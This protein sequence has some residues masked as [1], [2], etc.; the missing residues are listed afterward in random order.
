MNENTGQQNKTQT[1]DP[2]GSK[3]QKITEQHVSKKQVKLLSFLCLALQNQGTYPAPPALINSL[4]VVAGLRLRQV[5]M[6]PCTLQ[7]NLITLKCSLGS[8]H[9]RQ[10]PS[11]KTPGNRLFSVTTVVLS[12]RR[13]NGAIRY[14]ALGLW[15]LS[16]STMLWGVVLY[17]EFTSR[18]CQRALHCMDVPLLAY[19]VSGS[20]TFSLFPLLD[21]YEHGC[22]KYCLYPGSGMIMSLHFSR[23]N[24]KEWGGCVMW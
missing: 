19:S 14:V 20:K 22:C 21:G 5:H 2:K 23:V 9:C 17:Q 11:S 18:H 1:V 15:L 10:L 12:G 16:L 6:Y 7:K 3:I 8:F 4:L 24:T 13:V